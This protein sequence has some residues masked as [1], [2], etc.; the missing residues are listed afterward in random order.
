VG[1]EMCIRDRETRCRVVG[2]WYKNTHGSSMIP[3]L[4]YYNI[5]ID[6]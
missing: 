6:L 1:S 3:L 4:D 5:Y 2:H